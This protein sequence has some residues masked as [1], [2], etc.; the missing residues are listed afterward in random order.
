MQ[1]GFHIP[2][3]YLMKNKFSLGIGLE[4]IYLQVYWIKTLAQLCNPFFRQDLL[5]N[6]A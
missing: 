6:G 5:W 4:K 1:D 3:S 2:N